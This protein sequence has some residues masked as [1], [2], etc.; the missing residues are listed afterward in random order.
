MRIDEQKTIGE[1]AHDI[2]YDILLESGWDGTLPIDLEGIMDQ[3]G[4]D[5]KD[6]SLI[7]GLYSSLVRTREGRIDLAVNEDLPFLNAKYLRAINLGHVVE[8]DCI[9]KR[10]DDEY[11]F[12]HMKDEERTVHDVF[13]EVFA[14][15][16]LIPSGEFQ[17]CEEE[18][19]T[20]AQLAQ[21]FKVTVHQIVKKREQMKKMEARFA[22]YIKSEVLDIESMRMRK[23]R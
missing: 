18:G 13:A 1:N 6:V 17:R 10:T 14:L 12:T 21:V 9:S 22:K 5:H 23:T 3:Y 16:L 4:I 15:S 20:D 11:Y 19:L 7:K 8:R 2:A